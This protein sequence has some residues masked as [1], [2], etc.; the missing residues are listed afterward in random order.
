MRLEGKVALITGSARGMGKEIARV[1]AKEGADRSP[2]IISV[3]RII[4][5]LIK[6]LL[7]LIND[8]FE[9][10]GGRRCIFQKPELP[11]SIY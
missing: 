10:A 11:K 9:I 3:S 8:F 4:L 5:I 6:S 2:K 7:N 1:F